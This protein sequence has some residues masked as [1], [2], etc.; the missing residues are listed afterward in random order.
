MAND[1]VDELR[2]AAKFEP[3][4]FDLQSRFGNLLNQAAHEIQ[5]LRAQIKLLRSV[6]GFVEITPTFRDIAK[7]LPRSDPSKHQ[8]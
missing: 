8:V 7:D 1:L 3:H 4:E 2:A 6:S 5:E